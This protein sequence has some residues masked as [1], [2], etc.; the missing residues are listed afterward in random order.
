LG[1]LKEKSVSGNTYSLPLHF[2]KFHFMAVIKV[3]DPV[4]DCILMN[5]RFTPQVSKEQA[6]QEIHE[7]RAL[8]PM[9]NRVYFIGEPGQIEVEPTELD[10]P[11][12]RR[13]MLP[14][15]RRE[16]G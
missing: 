10:C 4:L 8:D 3:Y 13:D 15:I 1:R 9:D 12:C 7:L 14:H 16:R 6:I 11:S 5:G 2:V